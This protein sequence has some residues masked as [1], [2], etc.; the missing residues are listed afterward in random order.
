M[1]PD[2][3]GR[4]GG[5]GPNLLNLTANFELR[6][7]IHLNSRADSAMANLSNLAHRIRSMKYLCEIPLLNPTVSL[8]FKMAP[9]EIRARVWAELPSGN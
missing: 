2:C 1:L 7:A 4:V 8:N 6:G 3:G 5:A 9:A